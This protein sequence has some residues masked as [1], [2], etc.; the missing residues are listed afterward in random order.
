MVGKK[1][2]GQILLEAGVIDEFQLKSALGYQ[3]QWGGR[4]GKVLVEN[5]FITE[6]ALVTAIHKQTGIAIAEISD[7]ILPDYLTKLVPVELATRHN[8]VPVRQEGEPGKSSEVLVVA[9]SDPTN[10]S[11][12]DEVQF[13]TGK[14]I[15]AML[16][17]ESSIDKVIRTSYMGEPASEDVEFQQAPDEIQF[18]GQEIAVDDLMVVKGKLEQGSRQTPAQ[19]PGAGE[20]APLD[21][22]DPFAQLDSLAHGPESTDQPVADPALEP[23]PA[24]SKVSPAGQAATDAADAGN[25]LLDIDVSL[26]AQSEQAPA[27]IQVVEDGLPEVEVV[28]D[29][30]SDPPAPFQDGDASGFG[31]SG[32]LLGSPIREVDGPA[33]EGIREIKDIERETPLSEPEQAAGEVGSSAM[34]ALLSRVGIGVDG[35]KHKSAPQPVPAAETVAEASTGIVESHPAEMM[36]SGLPDEIAGLLDMIEAE[37]PDEEQPQVM[38][39][40]QLIAAVIRLLLRKGVISDIEFLEELKKH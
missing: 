12:L 35:V 33:S 7:A 23:V 9:M 40:G 3:K 18:G 4:L 6:E 38:K 28:D 31:Q 15:K 17:T 32:E 8:L 22:E 24:D 25:D 14:R 5:R 29:L 20:Q 21:L 30:P 39:S 34:E 11:A 16:A 1:Q 37:N 36:P 2:L 27:G 19:D 13:R 26:E 10:L